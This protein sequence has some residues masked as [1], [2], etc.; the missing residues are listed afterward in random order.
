AAASRLILLICLQSQRKATGTGRLSPARRIFAAP[1]RD[2]GRIP[3]QLRP[4]S[5]IFG[6]PLQLLRRYRRSFYPL[7]GRARNPSLNRRSGARGATAA[8]PALRPC[9]PIS[10]SE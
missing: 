6:A 10:I 7:A 1:G 4:R 8:P 2:F 5:D 3:R 9:L